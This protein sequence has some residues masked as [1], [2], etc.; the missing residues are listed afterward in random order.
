MTLISHRDVD[1]TYRDNRVF[2]LRLISD[3]Y[4][5]IDY[6]SD[7]ALEIDPANSS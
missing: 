6:I 2:K 4:S 3:L 1:P 7:T 5:T